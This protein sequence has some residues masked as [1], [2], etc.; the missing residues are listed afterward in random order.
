M[1][2]RENEIYFKAVGPNLVGTRLQCSY[3]HL[4]PEDLRW[5]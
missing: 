1:V 4:T 3:E 2:Y 5:G